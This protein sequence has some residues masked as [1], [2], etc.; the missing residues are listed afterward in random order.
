MTDMREWRDA[1]I[2]KSWSSDFL[3]SIIDLGL[4]VELKV[5]SDGEHY[6]GD[7][8]YRIEGKHYTTPFGLGCGEP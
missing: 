7:F 8:V 6:Y 5:N 1:M 4:Q 3:D 2:E